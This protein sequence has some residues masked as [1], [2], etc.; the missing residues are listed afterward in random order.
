ML[1]V[2]IHNYEAF[3][4]DS[5]EGNL[6]REQQL[7]LDVFSACHPELAV[8]LEG[9]GQAQLSSQKSVYPNKKH[10]KKVASDLV[11]AGE[12]IAYIEQE[13]SPEKESFIEKS[14]RLNP[15]LAHE[16]SLYRN[17]IAIADLTVVFDEKQALMLQ[18]AY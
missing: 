1:P 8:D 6:T 12:F 3:L 17:T 14:C 16:L 7:A 11:T 4:L 2:T 18:P 9:I 10:L 13:L 5:A 15:P